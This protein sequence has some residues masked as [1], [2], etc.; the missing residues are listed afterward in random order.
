MRFEPST[1]R[2]KFGSLEVEVFNYSGKLPRTP[3]PGGGERCPKGPGMAIPG[4]FGIG[5][6]YLDR[7]FYGFTLNCQ[8]LDWLPAVFGFWSSWLP[9]RS[10]APVV[11][12]AT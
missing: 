7:I 6:S 1:R 3:C 11:T 12:V 10:L 9:A 4:P 2:S 5:C 8:L